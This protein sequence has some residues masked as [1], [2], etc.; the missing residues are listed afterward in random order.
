[1]NNADANDFENGILLYLPSDR[2][3]R[4]MWYNQENYNRINYETISN[5]GKSR[6]NFIKIDILENV[7][8]W[9]IDCFLEQ[10]Q[11][12]KEKIYD[13]YREIS[14]SI[15]ETKIQKY[16]KQIFDIIKNDNCIYTYPNRKNQNLKVTGQKFSLNDISQLSTGEIYSFGL[17]L[18]ILK[19]WDLNHDN[20]NLEDIKGCVIIDEI[21][22]GLHVD[23]CYRVIPSLMK[24]FPKV[25]FIITT[26]SPFLLSGLKNEFKEDIDIINMPDGDILNDINA[27]SE[28]KN[29]YDIFEFE[30]NE[31]ITMNQKLQNENERLKKIDNK[32]II[33]TE[34][35]TDIK[36]LKI[37][38]EKLEGY[39]EIKNRI[40]YYDIENT[41]NTGDSE[42]QKIY[43]YLQVGNDNNIKICMF[44]RDNK[45]YIIKDKPFETKKN[46][47][48]KFNIPIPSNRNEGDLISIE[49][50][51]KDDELKTGDNNGR[52]IFLA[53]EFSSKGALI[54]NC[55]FF[56][57]YMANNYKSK[58]YNPLW[59]LDG[60]DDKKVVNLSETDEI[61][62]A[63]SKDDFVSNIEN[64]IEGF[65]KFDFSEFRKIFDVIEEI[66]QD[67]DNK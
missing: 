55:Q 63:L 2:F 64:N 47:V 33:Y 66:R 28:M 65:D 57:R 50:Y 5:V 22:I 42:L 43:T 53:Y 40:E 59:I 38:L 35:K 51:L 14:N 16:I 61:N 56:C 19:E 1:M 13:K 8:E 44:D 58:N 54:E 67:A 9:L 26:H 36:Y 48:Y 62:Y 39:E 21:D 12:Q 18:S 10:K 23:Y 32:I 20:F 49:H 29:A 25:Q 11:I 7:Y 52:R 15:V 24:L 46:K 4:P 27:F 3:Y 6:T 30:T 60:N 34:G 45:D 31:L 17:A 37:A 41:K